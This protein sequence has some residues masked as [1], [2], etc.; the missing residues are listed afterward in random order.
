M[1]I[2][3]AGHCART[4]ERTGTHCVE[5]PLLRD[6][7]QRKD[8]ALIEASGS[9]EERNCL[10]AIRDMNFVPPGQERADE[11]RSSVLIS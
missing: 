4:A 10:D 8:S 11:I 5:N 1:R 7:Q 6:R 2:Q 3:N 9:Q